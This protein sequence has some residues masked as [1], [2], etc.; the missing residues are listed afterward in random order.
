MGGVTRCEDETLAEARGLAADEEGWKEGAR[1]SRGVLDG[2]AGE[3][4]AVAVAVAVAKGEY[5]S[6]RERKTG[7][8]RVAGTRRGRE[9]EN[10]PPCQL[11]S[12]IDAPSTRLNA[13]GVL[14]HLRGR[15][16]PRWSEC[17]DTYW[18][19]SF[20]GAPT[21]EVVP[22][23]APTLREGIGDEPGFV[24]LAWRDAAVGA[25]WGQS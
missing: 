21:A 1:G 16:V 23:A 11:G 22:L 2:G 10:A 8:S 12:T 14:I 9:R 6:D 24:A 15:G 17:T 7:V 13:I 5:E 3:A 18:L 19:P 4:V 20:G 25:G